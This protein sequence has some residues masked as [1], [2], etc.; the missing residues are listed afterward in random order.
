MSDLISEYCELLGGPDVVLIPV[1]HGRK[2]PKIEGWQ[3]FTADQM[4]RPEYRARLNRA[5][6][7]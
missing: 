4:R 2:G 5:L 3:K 6:R 1:P 7:D